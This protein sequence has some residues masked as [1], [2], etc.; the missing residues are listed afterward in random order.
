[1][2]WKAVSGQR[3]PLPDR[4][5]LAPPAPSAITATTY[6]NLHFICVPGQ[7][8][9][10]TGAPGLGLV[11]QAADGAA[12]MPDMGDYTCRTVSSLCFACALD[13]FWRNLRRTAE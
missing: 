2:I 9:G 1:M 3:W 5:L 8:G 11:T 10:R 6:P 12:S 13:T 7:K 4:S